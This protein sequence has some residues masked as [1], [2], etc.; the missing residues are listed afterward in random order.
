MAKDL[1]ARRDD[2][3]ED[4][5]EGLKNDRKEKRGEREEAAR[6]ME[7]VAEDE[8]VLYMMKITLSDADRDREEE[9]DKDNDYGKDYFR[10]NRSW[11]PNLTIQGERRVESIG[12]SAT[13]SI[14]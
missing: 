10:W 5:A 9:E 11:R 7:E 1:R 12:L 14:I 13:K 6:R 4:A 3:E 2:G 8:A